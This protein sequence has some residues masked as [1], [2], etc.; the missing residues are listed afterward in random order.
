MNVLLNGGAVGHMYEVESKMLLWAEML[1]F[2]THPAA[3]W[4]RQ[5]K[6]AERSISE[7]E[8]WPGL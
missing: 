8:W 3:E 6:G 1:V 4:E 7:G 2:L 5:A